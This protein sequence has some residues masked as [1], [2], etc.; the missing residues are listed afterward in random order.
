MIQLESALVNQE[1]ADVNAIVAYPDF[2][3]T[4]LKDVNLV[5]VIQILQEVLDVIQSQ[6]NVNV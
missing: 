4:V 3:I 6:V 2:T 1:L 5:H